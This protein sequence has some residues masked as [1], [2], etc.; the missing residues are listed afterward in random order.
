MQEQQYLTGQLNYHLHLPFL[1]QL[2]DQIELPH[3]YL[4]RLVQFSAEDFI[5]LDVYLP[6]CINLALLYLADL[7]VM[8]VFKRY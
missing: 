7:T 5:F 8:E 4:L 2:H 3:Q 1:G 6:V